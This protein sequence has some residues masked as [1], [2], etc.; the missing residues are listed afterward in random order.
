MCISPIKIVNNKR[1]FRSGLDKVFLSVPCGHCYE[2]V[3][4]RCNEWFVRLS[5][6]YT[7]W[8][9]KNLPVYFLTISHNDSER[10]VF[11]DAIPMIERL[12]CDDFPEIDEDKY[13]FDRKAMSQFFKD[14]RAHLGDGLKFFCVC[15]FGTDTTGQHLPHYHVILF[16]PVVMEN[17]HFLNICEFC[18]SHS[19]RKSE[20]PKNV[21]NLLNNGKVLADIRDL[22]YY[23]YYN[24]ADSKI[25]FVKKQGSVYRFFVCRGFIMYSSDHGLKLTS[26]RGVKYVLKYLHKETLVLSPCYKNIV[27]LRKWY[28]NTLTGNE[29][30]KKLRDCV[31]WSLPF[32]MASRGIGESLCHDLSKLS[33]QLFL[34]KKKKGLE[35]IGE[36]NTYQIPRYVL[37]KLMYKKEYLCDT[38]RLHDKPIYRLNEFG[39]RVVKMSFDDTLKTLTD[40]Y[41]FLF[42]DKLLALLPNIST[43]I[44]NSFGYEL[45][46]I[47]NKYRTICNSHADLLA[48][49][50]LVYR[51]VSTY[52]LQSD[53]LGMNLDFLYEI[54]KK[55]FFYKTDYY[56]AQ[57]PD[58]ELIATFHGVFG[59]KKSE[60]TGLKNYA[61]FNEF[62][63]FEDFD[64]ILDV[65]DYIHKNLSSLICD[66]IIDYNL[67][68]KYIKS[69]HLKN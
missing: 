36:D 55:L 64:L 58:N 4:Q 26:L 32:N 40:N 62:P 2:C 14:L 54:G 3:Q 24:E 17:F 15:E 21:A 44:K 35:I 30:I 45:S 56:F 22:G 6:L 27:R 53:R 51:N 57:T 11:R 13:C 68:V 42:D 52:F 1:V 23:R 61:T 9:S 19:V 48:L 28:S 65:L 31:R 20:V 37:R 69:F 5:A 50:D 47:L 39:M 38:D 7:E 49:Y 29:N 59:N 34:E 60:Y 25:Y 41:N 8:V 18:W 16:S 33:V 63:C 12:K 67:Q 46:Q 43:D 66:G 10:P